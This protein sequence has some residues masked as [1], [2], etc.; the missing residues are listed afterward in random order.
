MTNHEKS[1]LLYSA[2]KL[3]LNDTQLLCYWID[4][5]RI[6]QDEEDR[7]F[8]EEYMRKHGENYGPLSE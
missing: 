3:N 7:E 8:I 5:D 6:Q 1:Q 2:S 4:L